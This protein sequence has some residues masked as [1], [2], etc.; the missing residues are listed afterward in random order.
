MKC[1]DCKHLEER[2]T[3]WYCWGYETE[4]EDPYRE[5]THCDEFEERD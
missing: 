5:M 4:V 3:T 2:L 1:I